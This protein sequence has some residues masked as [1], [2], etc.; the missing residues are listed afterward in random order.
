MNKKNANLKSI[1]K[2]NIS[3]NNIEKIEFKSDTFQLKNLSFENK[4][5]FP[6]LF[7]Y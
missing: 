7:I 4:F 6:N 3:N 2:V 1:E 5:I